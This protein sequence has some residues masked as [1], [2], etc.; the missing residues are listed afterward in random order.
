MVITPQATANGNFQS[1]EDDG[2]DPRIAKEHCSKRGVVDV[3]QTGDLPQRAI[4][5]GGGEPPSN[6]LGGDGGSIRAN[7]CIGP[8]AT[9]HEAARWPGHASTTG[10]GPDRSEQPLA[11]RGPSSDVTPPAYGG[12]VH[13]HHDEGVFMVTTDT[14]RALDQSGFTGRKR[15]HFESLARRRSVVMASRLVA[16]DEPDAVTLYRDMCRPR[17][18][19]EH[20]DVPRRCW[21]GLRLLPVRT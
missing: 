10:H 7:V 5:Y 4:S 12:G 20:S 2:I 11:G 18:M 14:D 8:V 21:F 3:S 17:L 13:Q 19:R 9:S 15:S 16:G 6:D 1:C